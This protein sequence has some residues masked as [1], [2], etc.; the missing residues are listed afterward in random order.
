MSWTYRFS[1][2]DS[3][4]VYAQNA[5]SLAE[6]IHS[7]KDAFWSIVSINQSLYVLG[8]YALELDYAFKALPIAK[9]IECSLCDS[10]FKWYAL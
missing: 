10:F 2:P 8:N 3:S 6:K 7:D 9:K 5:L 4:L 1:Y